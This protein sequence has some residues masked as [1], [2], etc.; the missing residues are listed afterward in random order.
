MKQTCQ[1][2]VD[3][4]LHKH[5]PNLNDIWGKGREDKVF[6]HLF[7]CIIKHNNATKVTG[8]LLLWQS[9]SAVSR[10]FFFSLVYGT[11]FQILNLCLHHVVLRC[12]LK[13]AGAVCRR[14]FESNLSPAPLH[15]YVGRLLLIG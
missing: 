9:W 5:N 13:C 14:E 4:V 10:S 2:P 12:V 7:Y 1:S 11:L 6:F 3:S 8:K 15:K